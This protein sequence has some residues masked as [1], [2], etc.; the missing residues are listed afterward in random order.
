MLL[1]GLQDVN[2]APDAREAADMVLLRLIHAADMPDPASLISQLSSGVS[3]SG[4]RPGHAGS[5]GPTARLP[6][7]FRALVALLEDNKKPLLAQQLHDHVRLARY[8]P[9]ELVLKPAR[10]LGHDWPR[11]LAMALKSITGT[12][13]QVSLTDDAGEPSLMDQEKMAMERVRTDVLADPNVQ[14]VMDAFPGAELESYS[15]RGF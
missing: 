12:S 14:A 3:G 13:W 8:N 15:T 7:D 6:S 1:K 11:E 4:T 2:S 9:P 5:S 10:P